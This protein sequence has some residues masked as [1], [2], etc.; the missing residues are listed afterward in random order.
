VIAAGWVRA[1]VFIHSVPPGLPWRTACPHCHHILFRAWHAAV[2][3]SGSRCPSCR[4]RIG[5]HPGAVETVTAGAFGLLAATHHDWLVLAALLPLA[6]A[7]TG[8]AFIDLAVHRLPNRFTLPMFVITLTLLGTASAWQHRLSTLLT[9]VAGAATSAAVYLLLAIIA[10]GGVGDAKLAV[11]TGA[12]LGWHSWATAVVGIVAGLAL[13]SLFALALVLTGR[14]K[15]RD[16]LAQGPGMLA[17]TL[18]L[19]SIA[20]AP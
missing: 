15:R 6:V 7:G 4:R 11:S 3:L 20:A 2:W 17:A 14:R 9:A 1:Q 16:H 19:T 10:N 5:P 18:A 12:V 13:T 8:L